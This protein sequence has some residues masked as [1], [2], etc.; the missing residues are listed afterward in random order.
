MASSVT[1]FV[2]C[3]NMNTSLRM[4]FFS[5]LVVSSLVEDSLF[6]AR[7]VVVIAQELSVMVGKMSKWP[8]HIAHYARPWTIDGQE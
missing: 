4:C 5:N 7:S 6:F 3:W 1:Y 2:I 8:S